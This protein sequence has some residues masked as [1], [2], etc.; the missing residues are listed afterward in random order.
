MKDYVD[1]ISYSSQQLLD[2]VNDILDMSRMEQGKV[3]LNNQAFNLKECIQACAESFRP[4][5]ETEKKEF[6]VIYDLADARVMGD[7]IRISQTLR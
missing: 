4:Q 5:A 2:L 1:K 7:S 3:V 6:Q